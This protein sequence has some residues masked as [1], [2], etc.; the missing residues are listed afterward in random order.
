MVCP[1]G[2]AKVDQIRALNRLAQISRAFCNR[3]TPQR[4]SRKTPSRSHPTTA[5]S[6]ACFR[7]ASANEPPINPVP[8]IATR[9]K[10]A[11]MAY[12]MRSGRRW[13]R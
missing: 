13:A 5:I 2:S 1:T 9:R 10:E 7:N 6:G 12:A 4:A 11:A 3:A 8:R